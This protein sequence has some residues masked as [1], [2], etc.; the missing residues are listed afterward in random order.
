L[1]LGDNIPLGKYLLGATYSLLHQVAI[2]LP[3][4][5]PWWFI[6]LWLNLYMH[7]AMGRDIKNISFPASDFAEEDEGT[8]RRCMSLVKQ[9]RQSLDF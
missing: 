6:Q 7:Q 4:G 5:E 1:A 3:A 9:H 2:K 8:T